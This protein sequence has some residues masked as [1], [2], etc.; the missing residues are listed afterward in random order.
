MK[1][2]LVLSLLIIPVLLLASA[3]SAEHTYI[4]TKNCKKCHI[5]QWKSWSETKMANAFETLTP[6]VAADRKAELG[7]DADK[8]Y[9]TDEECV[10]CHVTGYGKEGGFTSIDD[11]PDL[12]GVGCE[13]CHGAGGTYTQDG[14]M[15]LKNKEFK[16]ADIVAAGLIQPIDESVCVQCHNEDNPI[17]DY[18]FDFATKKTEGIH[19]STPLKYS[20]D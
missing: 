2:A 17:P 12:A 9:S 4:G 5:K 3:A 1:K 10:R 18:T 11:T 13:M 19:E 8:D 16:R 20:H 14:Y 7:L 6:G 15:T